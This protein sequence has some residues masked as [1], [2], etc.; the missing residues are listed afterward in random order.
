[1]NVLLDECIPRKLKHEL[2]EHSVAT[3]TECGW[4]GKKNG[5]LLRL[6][7]KKFQAFI[8]ID[9]N[10]NYQQN[11]SKFKIAIVLLIAKDNDLATLKPLLPQVRQILNSNSVE[12]ER[13]FKIGL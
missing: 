1:M 11:I 7:E 8:T 6:A 10:L 9:Q 12:A 5:D 13:I 2:K 3:V 4:S